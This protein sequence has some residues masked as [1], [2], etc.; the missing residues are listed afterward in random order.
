MLM[1][2]LA[3]TPRPVGWFSGR[4][5]ETTADDDYARQCEFAPWSSMVN[6]CGL[7]AVSVTTSWTDLGLPMGV[8]LVGRMGSEALLLQL[9]RIL[10]T[11]RR[12]PPLRISTGIG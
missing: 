8:Q 2:A 12:V 10:E 9:A 4:E 6:V 1:P 3:Q 7:P 11:P 5:W